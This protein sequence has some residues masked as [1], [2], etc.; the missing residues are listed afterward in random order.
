MFIKQLALFVICRFYNGNASSIRAVMVANCLSPGLAETD[1]QSDKTSISNVKEEKGNPL[2]HRDISLA[3][4][5]QET[6]KEEPEV[7]HHASSRLQY[8]TLE[9]GFMNWRKLGDGFEYASPIRYNEDY[10]QVEMEKEIADSDSDNESSPQWE[11]ESDEEGA[12]YFY[13]CFIF[14]CCNVV[15]H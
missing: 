5:S 6:K 9:G 3:S 7:L 12:I 14:A 4:A 11:D 1:A 2:S 13:L 15:K 10:R 8:S